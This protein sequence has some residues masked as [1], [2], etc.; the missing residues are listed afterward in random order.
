MIDWCGIIHSTWTFI[1]I[2]S[3]VGEKKDKYFSTCQIIIEMLW[4]MR[5]EELST[6]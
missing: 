2:I 3:T 6:K 4:Y 5:D 1:M